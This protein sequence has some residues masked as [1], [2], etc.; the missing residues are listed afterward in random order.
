MSHRVAT[1]LVCLVLAGCSAG[2]SGGGA[3]SCVARIRFAGSYYSGHIAT[4]PPDRLR[5]PL[6][7]AVLPACNDTN[8][9]DEHDQSISI[10]R[11]EGI[12]PAD[13]VSSGDSASVYVRD[14]A[15]LSLLPSWLDFAGQPPRHG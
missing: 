6:V 5:E 4:V 14:G 15:D 13:V 1:T 9:S 7:G 10:R 3:A 8:G 12:D 11:L 2:G